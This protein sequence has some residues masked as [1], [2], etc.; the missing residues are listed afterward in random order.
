[1][2]E[3]A[4]GRVRN[5]SFAF[6]RAMMV[7]LTP[8]RAALS[9]QDLGLPGRLRRGPC[10]AVRQRILDQALQELHRA[11]RVEPV[12]HAFVVAEAQSGNRTRDELSVLYR[13][14]V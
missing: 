11:L 8:A 13:G 2:N 12:F 6:P 3:R 9:R 10:D 5:Q 7:N 1:M 14:H 4:T